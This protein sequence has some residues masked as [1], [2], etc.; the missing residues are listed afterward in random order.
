MD[1]R[2]S[3]FFF[4]PI[5]YREGETGSPRSLPYVYCCSF[6]LTEFVFLAVLI[7]DSLLTS[8]TH[9]EVTSP[10]FTSIIGKFFHFE[11]MAQLDLR[12]LKQPIQCLSNSANDNCF[13]SGGASGTPAQGVEYKAGID[14]IV[15]QIS[16]QHDLVTGDGGAVDGKVAS[17]LLQCI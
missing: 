2:S 11:N 13:C 4:F 16:G 17:Y 14:Y 10:T 6:S 7:S 8:S 12:T 1:K 15:G 3:R 5:P 9:S